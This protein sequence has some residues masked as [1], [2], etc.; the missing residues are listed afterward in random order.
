MNVICYD[1]VPQLLSIL[2]K[3]EN[4]GGPQFGAG[5]QQSFGEIQAK[6]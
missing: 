6:Q 4:D 3:Q 1:F 5:P 2:Q